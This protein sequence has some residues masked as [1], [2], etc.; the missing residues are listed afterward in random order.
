MNT[1]W[2]IAIIGG[3]PAGLMAGARAA[4]RGRRT[5]LIEKNRAPGAKILISGGGRCNLTHACD[6]RG[7]IEQLGPQGKFLHSALAALGP[8]EVVEF[9]RAEGVPTYVETDTGKVFP[10]SDRSADV[11]AALLRKL[12]FADC[13]L[14]A[15][16]PLIELDREGDPVENGFRLT[17]SKRILHAEKVL[18]ATGGK[19]YPDCGTTGD[20]YRFA[21]KLGHRIIP[22]R[23]ALVPIS[24]HIEAIRAL[25]GITLKDVLIGVLE[26]QVSNLSPT[27]GQVSNLSCPKL[28]PK[29]QVGNLSYARCLGSRRGALLFTHFGVSGPAVMDLSRIVAGHPNPS[30][31]VLECDLLPERKVKSLETSIAL[32]CASGGKKAAS[33]LLDPWLPHRVGELVLETAA[34]PPDRRLAELSKVDR[35]RILHGIKQFTVPI[36]GTLGFRHAEVT[37]GGVALGEVDSRTMQSKKVQNL[38]FSGELLDLDGPIGGYNLQIAFSTGFF[39]GECM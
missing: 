20:G 17:T 7:I 23:P 1:R 24:T 6:A 35:C 31:L 27:V 38:Y 32:E 10:Q 13:E 22:P 28:N 18:L 39:A 14:A 21:E 9:F 19:S 25:Q 36:S 29:R 8:N 26:A 4:A 33:T 2:D 3:G 16:E 12:E 11:L 37:A 5:L 15:S 30:A 34:V